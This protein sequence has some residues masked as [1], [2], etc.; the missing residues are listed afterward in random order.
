MA[1]DKKTLSEAMRH[2]D[3]YHGTNSI[4][5]DCDCGTALNNY[6]GETTVT[7]TV[8]ELVEKVL[9]HRKVCSLTQE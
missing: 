5:I 3:V 9:A 8:L 1:E 4:E 2:V 7:L 6:T